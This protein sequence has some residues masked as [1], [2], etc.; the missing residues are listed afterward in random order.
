MN[1][2][3]AFDHR[4]PDTHSEPATINTAA[5]GLWLI[6]GLLGCSM[7][8]SHAATGVLA[9]LADVLS[10][11]SDT[12]YALRS[13]L[14]RVVAV[15]GVLTVL[16]APSARANPITVTGVVDFPATHSTPVDV[17]L[18]N[19]T[20]GARTA[21][22]SVELNKGIRNFTVTFTCP[23][24]ELVYF[25]S[26]LAP[27][28]PVS[29]RRSPPSFDTEM[30]I[31][32]CNSLNSLYGAFP[33][34]SGALRPQIAHPVAPDIAVNELTTVA[35][36]Y[37]LA[38]DY[39]DAQGDLLAHP[40]TARLTA[41]F[42]LANAMVDPRSGQA[43]ATLTWGTPALNVN[44]WNTVANALADCVWSKSAT[45][46]QCDALFAAVSVNGVSPQAT[47]TIMA[48]MHVAWY[49]LT[50]SP[51][52]LYNVGNA[53]ELF[54]LPLEAP[55]A[56]WGSQLNLLL[57]NQNVVYQKFSSDQFAWY[58]SAGQPRSATL[59]HNDSGCFYGSCGGELRDYQY[60]NNG[61]VLDAA[62]PTAVTNQDGGFGYIVSHPHQDPDGGGT[63][64][65][66]VAGHGDTSLLGHEIAGATD[67]LFVGRHHAILDF[68]QTYAR[69]C[70]QSDED[71]DANCIGKA[72]GNGTGECKANVTKTPLTAPFE[73]PVTVGW[74]FSTGND[75]PVWTVTYDVAASGA[76]NGDLEDDTRAP[77]GSLLWDGSSDSTNSSGEMNNAIAGAAWSNGFDFTT[78]PQAG[79]LTFDS[80]WTWN[81]PDNAAYAA[82]WTAGPVDAAMGVVQT[83][84]LE[85][86]DAG[87]GFLYGAGAAGFGSSA[88]P[89]A[90]QDWNGTAPADKHD[91]GCTLGDFYSEGSGGPGPN[92]TRD[93][94]TGIVFTMPCIDQWP[95]QLDSF[96][97][98]NEHSA[99]SGN[100]FPLVAWGASYGFLGEQGYP[101]WM[102]GTENASGP[103]GTPLT[104]NAD[105]HSKNYS[106]WVVLGQKKAT[107]AVA[108]QVS[109]LAVIEGL[110]L[111]ASVGTVATSGPIGIA[112]LNQ[113]PPAGYPQS[114][115]YSPA[116]Y[117]P[118]FGALTF[119]A[120]P[121][122][123]LSATIE[124]PSGSLANPLIVLRG[125]NHGS[126]PTHVQLDGVEL[127]ADKNYF[128][129][130]WAA[131]DQLWFTL[132]TT[133]TAGT[134]ALTVMP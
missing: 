26:G 61:A 30:A 92:G 24:N 19:P 91:S 52:A 90:Y 9:A 133:L 23:A 18:V 80:A 102:R 62:A 65:Y 2:M 103:G 132:N 77:Y 6:A 124:V 5:A 20:T 59:A 119:V 55:P 96:D 43:T 21:A 106:T 127:A 94:N 49:P 42:N 76:Q 120:A 110:V 56:D 69:Y 112:Y 79:P 1:P 84:T 31:D 40:I 63:N 107:D 74:V 111:S 44:R 87:N 72:H 39:F 50:V 99:T 27:S 75:N 34:A 35:A 105:W 95:Y 10:R 32:T 73:V 114:Q 70:P 86:A 131:Q 15:A 16:N 53:Y 71:D 51:P 11:V 83:Q 57:D 93:W 130:L 117:D 121:S 25:I 38:G 3:T 4:S 78:T 97:F 88:S 36:A 7:L 108:N 58:D 113:A 81:T 66:C 37:V 46:A 123:Q 85:Q 60:V 125:Y 109:K 41:D 29:F 28:S 115:T 13:F 14:Y 126:Y 33:A 118:V 100:N 122:N 104:V 48:A 101:N 67:R 54:A 134:H 47:N 17:F 98:K 128:P 8:E 82:L 22:A 12:G 89:T 129:S 64:S 116:G 68:S 45:S